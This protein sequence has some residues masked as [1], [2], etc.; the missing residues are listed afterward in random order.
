M[1]ASIHRGARERSAAWT[2]RV[3]RAR[4]NVYVHDRPG[5]LI[6]HYHIDS[7]SKDPYSDEGELQDMLSCV[8]PRLLF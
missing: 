2:T 6:V 8:A 4:D 3:P 5:G 1:A 7:D